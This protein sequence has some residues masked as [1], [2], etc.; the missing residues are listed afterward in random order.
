MKNASS[1]II[2]AAIFFALSTPLISFSQEKS[3]EV[4]QQL[5]RKEL[6][7][8]KKPPL[9][10]VIEKEE[11]PKIEFKDEEKIF[12]KK[13]R[14][15]GASLID[16]QAIHSLIE[17][18]GNKELTLEDIS[19]AAEVITNAYRRKGYLIAYAFVPVQEI[20][21]EIVTIRVLEGKVGDI[22]VS[23]NK[24]YSSSFIQNHLKRAEKDP[25][26]KE[27]SLE[28][29]ILLLNEYPS[30]NVRTSL[31]AGILPGTADILAAASD[32]RYITMSI[33]YDNFGSNTIS[34]HRASLSFDTGNL[35]SDG[36][37]LMFRGV[38][39]LDRIDIQKLS[40][41][42]AE[43]LIPVDYNGTRLGVYYANSIYEAGEHLAPLQVKGKART[44]GIY[45]THP[46]IKQRD[47]TL[48]VKVGFDYKDV[49]D[50]MLDSLNT[51]DDIR[52]FNLGASCDFYDPLEGRSIIGVTWHQGIPGLLGG[53]GGNDTGTSRLGAN[54]G[55]TKITADFARMQMIGDY[56]HVIVK[57]SGQVS[58][59]ELF[60]A[61]QFSIGGMGTVRGFKPSSHSGDS[62][63]LLSV[64]LHMSPIFPEKNIFNRKVG[65]TLKF[66]LFADHAGDYRNNVQPGENK[67][68]YL[69]SVGAGIRLYAGKHFSLKIDWAV[70]KIKGKLNSKNSETYVQATMSF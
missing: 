27:D 5:E 21:H 54:G 52:I 47:K 25:S 13:I 26:L 45:L 18:F 56:S 41:G 17:S 59:D 22:S 3:G 55:F 11:K 40:Y 32:A 8:E 39:G 23:G 12:V 63:Y 38:T 50:Y 9:P 62:G 67:D 64:E 42:R 30:L 35:I 69:T 15:E 10:P 6:M 20:K 48:T 29:A 43:Y 51:K 36:D 49:Y 66:V 44:T 4:L 53:A 34:K 61:E 70:P 24:H 16:E 60:S 19:T 68:D 37:I 31:K 58:G 65:E 57:A 2:I 1:I 33:G 28:R 14:V 46:V 7:P